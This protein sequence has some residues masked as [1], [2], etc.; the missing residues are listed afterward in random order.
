MEGYISTNYKVDAQQGTF[1]LK[2]YPTEAKE[3]V[4]AETEMIEH[5][6][7]LNAQGRGI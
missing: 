3:D 7:H 2:V 6:T 4:L 5:L 1:V